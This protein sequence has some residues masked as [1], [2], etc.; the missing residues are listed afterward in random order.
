MFAHPW[1]KLSQYTWLLLPTK[2]ITVPVAAV[3]VSEEF[4]PGEA[5]CRIFPGVGKTIF[6]E[7]A[8]SGKILFYP[9]ETK[10]TTF[11]VKDVRFQH[12]EGPWSS[13]PPSDAHE[14]GAL[15]LG[16]RKGEAFC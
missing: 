8:K 7:G 15:S 6:P 14:H 1:C 13:H 3:W 11:L 9:L 12:P 2:R 5:S 10:I 4:F 16:R